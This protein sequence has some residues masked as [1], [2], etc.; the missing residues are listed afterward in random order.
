MPVNIMILAATVVTAT[1][2]P[3]SAIPAN[4]SVSAPVAAAIV[5]AT[6]TIVLPPNTEVDV[7]PNDT[8][9]TKSAKVG[10]SFRFATVFDVMID[11]V[12]LIPRG[13]VGQGN[14]VYRTGTGAF[15]KSGKMEVT[16]SSLT[17]GGRQ[18]ALTGKHRQEGEGNTGAA[19]GAVVAVGVFGA[20]VKGHS[21]T[22]ANGQS[23]RAF[24]AEPLSFTIPADAP[25]MPAAALAAPQT[26]TVATPA[27]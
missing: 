16:F 6:R 14:V 27:S 8:L 3:V 21:A 7:T 19:V 13:T 1:V 23:L 26:A 11:G 10:D 20:F 24:T 22:I 4:P 25:R 15:G 5:P 12:V 2:V 17:L 9:S 18:V